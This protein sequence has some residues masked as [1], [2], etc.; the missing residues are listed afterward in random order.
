MI[1]TGITGTLSQRRMPKSESST[2]VNTLLLM[3]PPR[4]RIASRARF[5]CGASISSPIILSAK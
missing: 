4:D 5:M 3:A 1:S 2:R